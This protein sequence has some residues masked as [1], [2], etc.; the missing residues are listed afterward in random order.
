MERKK[1][2]ELLS[3]A[4]DYECG[5]A[6]INCGADAVYI[7]APKF[8]ARAAA[9]NSLKDIENLVKYVHRNKA[10][11]YVTVNTIIYDS[12]LKEVESLIQ[13]L[14]NI[15]ADAIIIQDMGIL[16]MNLPPI[17]IFASTQ[18]H[19]YELEKIK[20]LEYVGFNRVILARE[21][22]IE[23]IK[24]IKKQTNIELEFFIHG[25][26]CVSFS[27]QCYLSYASTGRSANRGECAQVCRHMFSLYDEKG[28]LIIE[29]K[30]LL[31]LKDLNLS[32][33][34]K[35]L[36]DAGISSFKIEGRLKDLVYVKN[37]T[38]A[39][40]K[41]LDELIGIDKT[42]TKASSGKIY[43]GFEPDLERTF[44][45]GYTSYLIGSEDNNYATINSQKSIGKLI[46]TVKTIN[47][48]YLIINTKE[49][50]T[51]GDGLC[52][53]DS[54]DI[55]KGINVEKSHGN[56]LLI[57]DVDA[58]NSIHIG[59]QV[60]RNKDIEFVK[61]VSKSVDKRKI[62]VEVQIET[63]STGVTIFLRDEDSNE[64]KLFWNHNNL[65]ADN[66]ENF[67]QVIKKQFQ[68]TG[69]TIF[70]VNSIKLNYLHNW[71]FTIS[72]INSMRRAIF[73]LLEDERIKNYKPKD[74]YLTKCE[75]IKIKE[76]ISYLENVT[77]QYSK[78]F[79]KELGAINI[80]EGFELKDE[81]ADLTL[82]KSKY[83][84]K[85]QLNI[86]P[87]EVGDCNQYNTTLLLKDNQK[88]YK[89]VFDCK[90]CVMT[91]KLNND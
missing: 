86:C 14:Y 67:L 54:K 50:I 51:N 42:L 31:S 16:K 84:I 66:P 90:E 1:Q 3:P 5:V 40:R 71:F 62:S 4:K 13:Q 68:K 24:E 8:G 17:R 37:V 81:F 20:F 61:K 26:L 73:S 88:T 85:K 33:Y 57:D 19:N 6:A 60:F 89:L 87:K 82:M 29:D 79:Y 69:N 58:I 47:K 38:A 63:S 34:L 80:E 11:V 12:E 46:G 2:I 9:G 65:K 41:K 75:Q 28:K 32:L 7:G 53:F 15:G 21:L 52:F 59:T 36:I 27:G 77:N 78:N 72:E 76:N 39:Y 45:R 49:K 44:N 48:K 70:E 74:Y 91:I 56:K 10:K 55:L 64:V 23:K 22:S 43:L 83:C 25:A 35:E 30:Y 18:T